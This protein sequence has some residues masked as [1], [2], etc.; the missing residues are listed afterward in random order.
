VAPGRGLSAPA[1]RSGRAL[2][3]PGAAREDAIERFDIERVAS[4]HA[5]L[6]DRIT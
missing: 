5:E 6:Y 2:A 3:G 1:A 4:L